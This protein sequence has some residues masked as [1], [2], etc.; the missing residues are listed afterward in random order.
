MLPLVLA[1]VALLFAGAVY[2]LFI[3]TEGTYLG[4][5]I[6]VW[7]YDLTARRYDHIKGL[8]FASELVYLGVPLV[9]ALEDV[10]SPRILDAAT[11]TGRVLIAVSRLLRGRG[12]LVGLDRSR[13]MLAQARSA[14][15]E[16]ESDALLLCSDCSQLGFEDGV[17]DCVCCI[18]AL[19]F[20]WDPAAVVAEL[21]RVLRPGGV[22]LLS[23]RVGIDARLFPGRLCGRGRLERHLRESGLQ[24]VRRESWQV[25]Y[26][27]IWARKVGNSP[28]A[29]DGLLPDSPDVEDIS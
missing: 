15:E 16:A 26:D 13:G 1:G 22:L 17:F 25:H 18:E 19:E 28:A 12:V 2:W 9:A 10:P 8:H 21:V 20:M 29:R 6:V 7:M 5:R 14:L 27:L 24:D 23:N 4:P 3:A 11:G